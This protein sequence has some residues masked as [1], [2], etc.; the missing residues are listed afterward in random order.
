MSVRSHFVLMVE[1]QEE[2]T[3]LEAEDKYSQCANASSKH[4]I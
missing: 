2:E 4:H 1:M 3:F